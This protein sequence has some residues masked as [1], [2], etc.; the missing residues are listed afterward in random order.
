MITREIFDEA[1]SELRK[2][3]AIVKDVANRVKLAFRAEPGVADDVDE[4]LME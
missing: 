4:D 3:D 1:L 2:Q